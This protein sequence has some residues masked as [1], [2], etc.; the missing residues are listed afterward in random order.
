MSLL[1][2]RNHIFEL[3]NIYHH[4]LIKDEDVAKGFG[5]ELEVAYDSLE[6][7]QISLQESKLY[8]YKLKK[9]LNV[10]HLSFCMEGNVLDIMEEYHVDDEHEK[11]SDLQVLVKE[12]TIEYI[13]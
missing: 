5:S 6:N 4:A 1:S 13:D 10:P 2:D 7:T 8:T 9:D 3:T 12:D 11:S